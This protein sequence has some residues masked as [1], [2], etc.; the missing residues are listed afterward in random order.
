MKKLDP[1][2]CINEGKK[3]RRD[4]SEITFI[5]AKKFQRLQG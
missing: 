2:L 3:G 5:K 4:K 1:F